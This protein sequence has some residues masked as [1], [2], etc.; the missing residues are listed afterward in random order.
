MGICLMHQGELEGARQCY[1]RALE[2]ETHRGDA[3][4]RAVVISN[5]GVVHREK[6]EYE[7]AGRLWREANEI[8]RRLGD[9]RGLSI[10]LNNLGNLCEA[11]GDL[12]GALDSYRQAAAIAEVLG[13]L[14]QQGIYYS[15]IALT[16]LRRRS[17]AE[18]GEMFDRSIGLLEKVDAQRYLMETLGRRAELAAETGRPIEAAGLMEKAMSIARQIGREDRLVFFAGLREAYLGEGA[19]GPEGEKA[20]DNK[21]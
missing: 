19:A 7:V 3:R 20:V 21:S 5:L 14:K 11:R 13:D 8:Y 10:N 4:R 18:A 2:I 15:N 16:H 6:Q 17:Y 9:Q 1:R 12:E